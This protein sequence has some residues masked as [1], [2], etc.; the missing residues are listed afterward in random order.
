MRVTADP[1]ISIVIDLRMFAAPND[2]DWEIDARHKLT[3]V[4][5]LYGQLSAGPRGECDQSRD[6]INLAS[7]LVRWD[8]RLNWVFHQRPS[9]T[10]DTKG[11]TDPTAEA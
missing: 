6:R 4:G 9:S 5:R 2:V 7:P 1:A 8:R 11:R 3:V 10:I